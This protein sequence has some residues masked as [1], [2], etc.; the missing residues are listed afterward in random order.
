M[1]VAVKVIKELAFERLTGTA[2]ER[3]AAGVI[4]RHLRALG[5]RPR[6]EPFPVNTFETGTASVTVAG[7]TYKT[8]PFGLTRSLDISG[9]LAFVEDPEVVLRNKGAYRGKVLLIY[10]YTRKISPAMREQGVRACL[11]IG[12]PL[13]QA[14]S[15][16]YRQKDFAMGYVPSATVDY[17]DGVALSA[18]SGQRVR[19]KVTQKVRK[20]TGR[21]IIVDI[22]GKDRDEN[23]TL[24]CGHYDSVARSPGATDNAGGVAVLVKAAEHFARN[25][26]ARD[27]RIV[28][29]SGEELGLRGSFAY[30]AKHKAEIKKRLGLVVNVDVAGD[31]LGRNEL[32]VLGTSKLQGYAEGVTCELGY[33]FHSSLD[34]YS[35]DCMPFAALEVPSVNLARSGGESSSLIHTPG[36]REERTS[37]RGLAPSAE[38]AVAIL[39]R[40]L[41]AAIYPV[42]REIDRSLKDKIEKYIWGSRLESPKLDWTPEYRR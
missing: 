20:G 27:L 22:K 23:L 7:K 15:W 31:E 40:V 34:V 33:F 10:N 42:D 41:N 4:C 30:A 16:S 21:N 9:E 37:P 39:D 24:A 36:D 18:L 19:L 6:L 13:K 2:G 14:P 32:V 25:R 1:S 35:S 17:R 29:F 3:R 26:P 38:A 11:A 12:A 5:L 8:H 28:F